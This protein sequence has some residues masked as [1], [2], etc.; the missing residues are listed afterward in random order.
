MYNQTYELPIPTGVPIVFSCTSTKIFNIE[1]RNTGENPLTSVILSV[2][3][4]PDGD[5]Q[6]W[7][8]AESHFDKTANPMPMVTGLHGEN[9]YTLAPD[10]VGIISLKS[11]YLYSLKTE[12]T[13]A[14]P[15]SVF[16]RAYGE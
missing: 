10:N 16:I 12:V 14:S 15:T 4:V 6:T 5:Y 1:F 11:E 9:I 13:S 3:F 2:N 7:L 8:S